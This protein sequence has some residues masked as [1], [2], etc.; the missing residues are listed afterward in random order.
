MAGKAG[1]NGGANRGDLVFRLK[2][3][4]AKTLV[5]REFMENVRRRS[6]RIG[7]IK[8]RATGELRCSHE[9]NC[10]RFVAG[11][12]SILTRSDLRLLDGVMSGEYFR[13]VG[14]VVSGSQSNFVCLGQLGVL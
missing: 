5:A 11:D 1:A 9:T 13:G 8:Q 4:H 6:D 3:L 2:G 14:E 7:T 12:L 10:G